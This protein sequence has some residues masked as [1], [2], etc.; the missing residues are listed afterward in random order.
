M[1]GLL[2]FLVLPPF[3]QAESIEAEWFIETEN[4]IREWHYAGLE[5]GT[6]TPE[7]L[8]FSV[9]EKAAVFRPLP[10]DF[11][12]TID[13]MEIFLRPSEAKETALLLFEAAENE[14]ILRS[15]RINFAPGEDGLTKGYYIPLTFYRQ[16][17]KHM[18]SLALD[19]TGDAKEVTFRGVRLLSYS[20]LEKFLGA[21]KSF[22]TLEPLRPHMVNVQ[23]GPVI[24]PDPRPSSENRE[25]LPLRTSVNAYLYVFLTLAG[26]AILLRAISLARFRNASWTVLRYKILT[27]FFAC[28]AAV[29]ILYDLRM[30]TEYLRAVALDHREYISAPPE[31]RTF[32]ELGRF[33]EFTDFT[34]NLVSDREWY[35]LFAP[36]AW[37]YFGLLQYA[38]YPSL[39]NDGEPIS[40]TWVVYNRPD[41]TVG[42]DQRL[43]HDGAAFSHPGIVLG[44]FDESSFVFRENPS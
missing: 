25:I 34:K 38:T 30:G 27:Q 24:V 6:L 28:I 11:E 9:K 42:A 3:A 32:R 22:A 16:D 31:T 33:Y 7:G 15:L 4:D 44:R 13:G 8:T 26:L 36:D 19:F 39:P 35:E 21:V 2:C 10:P 12:R 40:D 41:I 17:L 37:Q 5:E 29:W 1:T 23:I 20:P 43:Y 14:K 18:N